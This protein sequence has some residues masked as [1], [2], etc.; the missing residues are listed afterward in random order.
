MQMRTIPILVVAVLFSLYAATA[1][2]TKLTFSFQ[3]DI[4]SMD[5]YTLN[6]GFTNNVLKH[7][8]EPL[9]RYNRELKIEGALAVSWE[10]ASPTVWRF[11]LRQGV[12]Y[13]NGNPFT[14]D[15]VAFSI[16]RAKDDDSDWK[17]ILSPI[18]QVR[19]VDDFTVEFETDGPFPT[20][21]RELSTILIMDKEWAVEHGV[22]KPVNIKSGTANYATSH[23]NGTGPFILRVREPD[24]RTELDV[25]PNWWDTPVHNITKLVLRP[26]KSPPT[27]VAALLSGEIDMMF[28]VPL[29]DIDRVNRT[30]GYRVLEGPSERTIFIGMNQRADELPDSNVKGK[31]PFKDI[32]LRKAFYMAIDEQAIV[33]RIMRGK[34]TLAGLLLAPTTNGFDPNQN[35]RTPYDPD[36][37]KQLLRDAGYPDGFEMGMDCPNDR[38]VNDEAICQAIVSMLAKVGIKVNL[39]AQTRSKYFSKILKKDTSMYLLGW[40]AFGPRDGHSTLSQL[41]ASD[42][43]YNAGGYSNAKA[44]ELIRQIAMEVDQEKRQRLFS[45]VFKIMREEFAYIPL[46]QQALAWAVRDGL[47]MPLFADNFVRFW[48]ARA[49]Y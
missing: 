19:K 23:A 9:I 34:A 38:Y 45:E 31:N 47:E 6:E 7:V 28:P 35:S 37:A 33:D 8:Y 21:P 12:K 43:S 10:T 13:H 27:R 20:L 24:V 25:N 5:P 30:A 42:G 22:E 48:L 17:G 18:K 11:K 4:V 41:V 46:H 49:N 3:G 40:A 2:A 15:D 44:D 14:A 16:N 32:R 26:I 39:L 36:R 1:S 29:Q